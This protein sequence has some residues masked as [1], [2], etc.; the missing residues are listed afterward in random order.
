[1]RPVPSPSSLPSFP[2]VKVLFN[3]PISPEFGQKITKVTQ[4]KEPGSTTRAWSTFPLR[5]L[6]FLLLNVFLWLPLAFGLAFPLPPS[7][8][9][10]FFGS[11]LFSVE[12]DPF[13]DDRQW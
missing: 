7:S 5:S 11:S 8:F 6:R 12:H 4:A 13:H 3:N 9:S 2:S 1:M 10:P